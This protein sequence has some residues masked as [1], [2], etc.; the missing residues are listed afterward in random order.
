MGLIFVGRS[1]IGNP[2]LHA[3]RI[4]LP[5]LECCLARM[6]ETWERDGQKNFEC[7]EDGLCANPDHN[8]VEPSLQGNIPMLVELFEE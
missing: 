6:Q 7:G 1:A 4:N 8:S 5:T 3:L 2:I